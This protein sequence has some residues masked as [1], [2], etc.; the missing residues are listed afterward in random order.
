M[1]VCLLW[2]LYVVRK[3]SQR[4]PVHWSKGVLPTV[5]RRCVWSRNLVNE[6]ALAQGGGAVAPKQTKLVTLHA[7]A[8]RYNT[9]RSQAGLRDICCGQTGI[10]LGFLVVI[11]FS[12][13]SIIP[14]FSMTH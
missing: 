5:V 1:S 4:R 6:E 13:V 10:L 3:R 9:V 11:R 14:P 12:P 2:V 7:I 8:I